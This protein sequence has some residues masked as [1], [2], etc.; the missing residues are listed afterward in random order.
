MP[1]VYK[2]TFWNKGIL[3]SITGESDL[4]TLKYKNNIRDFLEG[5]YSSGGYTDDHKVSRKR[6]IK[7]R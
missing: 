5:F 4:A 7:P 6:G 1:R 2:P 3:T